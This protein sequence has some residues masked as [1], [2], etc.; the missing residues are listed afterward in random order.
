MADEEQLWCLALGQE[1]GSG[2]L[3]F[4]VQATSGAGSCAGSCAARMYPFL[5]S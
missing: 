4:M 5:K 2:L 3:C 1:G